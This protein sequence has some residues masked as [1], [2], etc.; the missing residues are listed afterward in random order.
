MEEKRVATLDL[1]NGK[2]QLNS[3]LCRAALAQML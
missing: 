2:N 1:G 3:L